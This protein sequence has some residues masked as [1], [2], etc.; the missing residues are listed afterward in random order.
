MTCDVCGENEAIVHVQQIM[1]GE[2]YEYHMCGDCARKKGVST[3]QDGNMQF[4]LSHLLGGLVDGEGE[5]E[6]QAPIVTE[7]PNCRTSLKEIRE[8]ET[9]GCPECYTA[10]RGHIDD[11]LAEYADITTHKGK[12]PEK[13]RAYKTILVDKE[14]LKKKLNEA[15]HEEEYETA[16][17]LRDRLREMEEYGSGDKE[18]GRDG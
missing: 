17:K 16:A 1:G 13:L 11:L 8:G 5:G 9:A 14:S 3:D 18:G 7:C 6:E 15:V 2:L 10:F 4:S 12:Y